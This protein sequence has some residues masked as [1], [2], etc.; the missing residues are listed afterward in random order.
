MPYCQTKCAT[1]LILDHSGALAFLYHCK[2]LVRYAW[3]VG[4]SLVG[5]K[6]PNDV[7]QNGHTRCANA[8]GINILSV[9][10]M[11]SVLSMPSISLYMNKTILKFRKVGLNVKETTDKITTTQLIDQRPSK[12]LLI[13]SRGRQ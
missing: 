12:G 7:P 9:V 10:S 5:T 6:K 1:D 3:V 2:L 8:N 13:P 11:P 4:G